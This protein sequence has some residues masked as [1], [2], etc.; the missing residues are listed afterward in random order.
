MSVY[1]DCYFPFTLI[2]SYSGAEHCQAPEL[3]VCINTYKEISIETTN[4]NVCGAD[5]Y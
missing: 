4:S 2:S 5:Y 1:S 3:V